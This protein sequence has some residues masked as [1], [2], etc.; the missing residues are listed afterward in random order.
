MVLRS[1]NRGFDPLN[2]GKSWGNLH[3]MGFFVGRDKKMGLIE[4]IGGMDGVRPT[5]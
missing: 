2:V 5:C 3:V 4:G 1:A